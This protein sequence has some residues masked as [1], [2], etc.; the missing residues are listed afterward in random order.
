MGRVVDGAGM[1]WVCEDM[2]GVY[3]FNRSDDGT[4]S[5]RPSEVTVPPLDREF[6]LELIFPSL[7]QNHISR[8]V[9][10]VVAF[11]PVD[12]DHT[13]LQ[14]RS[15]QKLLRAPGLGRLAASAGMSINRLCTRTAVW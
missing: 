14:L 6:K 12:E 5:P 2:V 15:Y 8:N 1:Q 11:A 13:I 4:S 9:R 3:I 10:I 7:W